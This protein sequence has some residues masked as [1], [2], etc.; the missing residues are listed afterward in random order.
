MENLKLNEKT[1]SEMSYIRLLKQEDVGALD[2]LWEALFLDSVKIA[3]KYRQTEDMGYD[4]AVRAYGKLTRSGIKNF[5]FKSSFRSY[6]WVIISR[7]MFRLM[8]K[9][10][11]LEELELD[12]HPSPEPKEKQADAVTIIERIQPCIEQLE[13]NRLK[14]FEM[15]DLDRQNP[16]DVAET[17]GLSR[18]NVNKIASRVR[19]ELRRCLEEHGFT[20]VLD[21]LAA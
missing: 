19:L 3:R 12:K 17:L 8:K 5:S 16:G 2:K 9:E 13:G 10:L 11:V 18:N 7:E 6:C 14:V 1:H 15:I 21:V 4:A 20:S